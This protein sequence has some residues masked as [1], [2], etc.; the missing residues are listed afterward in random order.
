MKKAIKKRDRRRTYCNCD[1]YEGWWAIKKPE[2]GRELAVDFLR[3][4]SLSSET[5]KRCGYI[6]WM[7]RSKKDIPEW[8]RRSKILK[9]DDAYQGRLL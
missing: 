5:C 3:P 8:K 4:L 6:P 9:A 1:A 7:F 2:F